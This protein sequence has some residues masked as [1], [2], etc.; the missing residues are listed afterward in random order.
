MPRLFCRC[1]M[2]SRILELQTAAALVVY[3][4]KQNN[5][6]DRYPLEGLLQDKEAQ[7]FHRAALI[8]HDDNAV[9]LS[10]AMVEQGFASA[11]PEYVR[12]KILALAHAYG[13]VDIEENVRLLGEYSE[14]TRFDR[15]LAEVA[16]ARKRGKISIEEAQSKLAV[17]DGIKVEDDAMVTTDDW[18]EKALAAFREN[19]LLLQSGAL[20]TWPLQFPR[21]REKIPFIRPG[22]IISIIALSGVG[23]TLFALMCAHHWAAAH[24]R[25]V[26]YGLLEM[27]WVSMVAR[28]AN[29]VTGLPIDEIETGVHNERLKKVLQPYDNGGQVVFWECAGK[30]MKQI[31][32]RARALG[33]D[34]ILDTYNKGNFMEYKGDTHTERLNAATEDYSAYLQADKRLGMLVLQLDKAN[35][36]IGKPSLEQAIGSIGLF[37][38]T[39]YGLTLDFPRSNYTR[40]VDHPIAGRSPVQDYADKPGSSGEIVLDKNSFGGWVGWR[41]RCFRDGGRSLIFEDNRV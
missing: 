21:L 41:D 38:S 25:K 34:L 29:R 11:G 36:A 22:N 27:N 26:L 5:L 12:D 33:A 1:H 7:A 20:P 16:E 32:A 14:A 8:A 37:Q 39:R 18:G 40:L 23:K 19:G 3:G 31:I 2:N 9:A 10:H 28:Y 24:G 13:N 30:P 35:T 6:L 17:F 15:L 4:D